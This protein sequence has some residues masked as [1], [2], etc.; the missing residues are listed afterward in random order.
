MRAIGLGVAPAFQ[1]LALVVNANPVSRR[2]QRL[3]LLS[4]QAIQRRLQFS[5]VQLEIRHA[6]DGQAIKFVGVFDNRRITTDF[7]I[8]QNADHCPFDT[9]ILRPLE[10]QQRIHFCR[11]IGVD[12]S[13]SFNRD[14]RDYLSTARAKASIIGCRVSRLTLSEA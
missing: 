7:D 6:T 8:S 5:L 2:F 11:E 4:R 12:R 3:T 1:R 9:V 13:K 10:S 14:H